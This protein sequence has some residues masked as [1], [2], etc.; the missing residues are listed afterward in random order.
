MTDAKIVKLYQILAQND[1]LF[2]AKKGDLG[3][4]FDYSSGIACNNNIVGEGTRDDT[5]GTNNAV[6]TQG[7]TLEDYRIGTDETAVT[8]GDGTLLYVLDLLMNTLRGWQGM[9]IVIDNLAVATDENMVAN[10]D[11]LHSIYG[12]TTNATTRPY[13]N[14]ASVAGDNDGTLVETDHIADEIAIDDC[15]LGA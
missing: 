2:F 9:E 4:F 6:L 3:I 1:D 7:G 15:L 10:G 14:M 13:G 12:G 5:T 11:L 8:D